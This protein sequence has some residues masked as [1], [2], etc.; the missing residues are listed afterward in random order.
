MRNGPCCAINGSW[1]RRLGT[2]RRSRTT[3][4]G[5]FRPISFGNRKGWASRPL[6]PCSASRTRA[7]HL[8][9][10][11][12]F[13]ASSHRRTIRRVSA[14]A[15]RGIIRSKQRSGVPLASAAAVS[16]RRLSSRAVAY[17]PSKILLV[18][19]PWRSIVSRVA[20][21]SV[22]HRLPPIGRRTSAT[23]SSICARRR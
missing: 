3:A 17:P 1:R 4:M 23:P 18:P 13:S 7:A 14:T 19:P 2:R 6:A 8:Q 16:F 10:N 15:A 12:V 22:H 20:V 11:A 5:A 9:V 21:M